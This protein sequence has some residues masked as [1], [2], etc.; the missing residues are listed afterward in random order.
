MHTSFSVIAVGDA[1][2]VGAVAFSSSSSSQL[3][4]SSLS[5]AEARARDSLG[6]FQRLQL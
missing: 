1:A 4:S 6:V 5:V 2:D 3:K